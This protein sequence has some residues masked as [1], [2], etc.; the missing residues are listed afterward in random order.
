MTLNAGAPGRATPKV[1]GRCAGPTRAPTFAWLGTGPH[2][3]GCDAGS[4]NWKDLSPSGFD[5]VLTHFSACDADSGWNGDGTPASPYRL[6]FRG[7]DDDQ[8]VFKNDLFNTAVRGFSRNRPL[9]SANRPCRS[10]SQ[11]LHGV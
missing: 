6:V 7:A 3:A 4:L 9:P 2:A 1:V 8:V 11:A 5:G 10:P